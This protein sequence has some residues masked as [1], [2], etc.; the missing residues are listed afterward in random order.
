[1][2]ALSDMAFGTSFAC[3]VPLVCDAII[4]STKNNGRTPRQLDIKIYSDQ[5]NNQ[6]R[7]IHL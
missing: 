6:L 4:H 2:T 7:M 1:M 3:R 5:L